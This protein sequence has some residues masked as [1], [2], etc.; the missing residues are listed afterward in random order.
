[1]FP[2]WVLLHLSE[3]PPEQPKA[4]YTAITVT[5]SMGRAAKAEELAPATTVIG[6]ES[7][8]EHPMPTI[9][10][11]LDGTPGALIQQSTSAQV[12]PFLRGLT[13]YQVL[14][15]ID[16]I[17][18]NNSTF[19][20]GPNQ[21]LAFVEPGQSQ[22]VEAV[23]GPAG[24][25]YG[26]DAMGGAIQVLTLEPRF[27]SSAKPEYGGEWM[28]FAGSADRSVGTRLRL[29]GGTSRLAWLAG[30]TVRRHN[31]IRA[32]GGADSRH[33]LR[34]FLGLDDTMIQDLTG[35]RQRNT[36]FSQSGAHAK[37]AARLTPGQVLTGWYQFSQQEGVNGYKDLWG[38]QGRLLSQFA[39]QRLHFGYARWEMLERL[40]MDR[41]S[42][43]FS[44]NDQTDGG[45]RQGLRAADT[46]TAEQSRVR[47]LGYTGQGA[48]SWG[49][50]RALVFGGEYY[51]ESVGARRTDNG[52]LVRPLYPDGSGYG[53]AGL[54]G[55][56]SDV[57]FRG[58]LAAT[59]GLR[60]TRAG[61]SS[62]SDPRYGVAGSSQSFRDLTMNASLSWRAGQGVEVFALGGRGFRAPNLND[63]G[64]IGLND[65]GYEI[66]AA[67]ARG[68][69]MGNNSS[70][71]AL[72]LGRAVETLRPE[73]LWNAEAGVRWRARRVHVEWRGFDAELA[74]P[75]ARRTL[76]F[77]LSSPPGELA[78]QPVRPNEPTAAQRAAG[79]TTVSTA[80]DP[81][82]VK[83]FV[84]DGQARYYG[85]EA[86]GRVEI[87]RGL[88]AE[89][90]YGFIAGR[91]LY[92]NRA[93]RRLPP[94]AGSAA[95]RWNP[96]R[97][98]LWIEGRLDAAGS[99]SRLSGGDL[100]DERIGASRSR[101]DIAAFFR[102]SR[103]AP[104][105]D[106]AGRFAPTGETLAQIQER[107]LPRLVAATDAL[108]V[109]LYRDTAGWWTAGIRS[110]VPVGERWTL[111][112]ALDNLADRNYRVHGSG[113][114]APGFSA[115]CGVVFQF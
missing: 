9:G 33:A 2:W 103:V 11:A 100:D 13:G 23:L 105:V 87:R 65:L 7:L 31:D 81:R 36:A 64:A 51:D 68:A 78:G 27:S 63:L 46:L 67:E 14:N 34:R 3:P 47:S 29:S 115:W 12:S 95:L 49:V 37:L 106:G 97:R 80:I 84:N 66:P 110:G 96:G 83:A 62:P 61:F 38:G 111:Q 92:P 44:L 93:I 114:D 99:Q 43:T 59:G 4:V 45:L 19:R 20:T 94:Q 48:R 30:G 50:H 90:T 113:I 28:S 79:V 56:L 52:R 16:G 57:W 35:S 75:I 74:D 25:L 39:P 69:R 76:L 58:R 24:A 53:T 88:R 1:M 5:A 32:G 112:L 55:Q 8:R 40:G 77:P 91:D 41:V 15:L 86:L 104:W 71:S 60:W 6:L 85:V 42:A 72:P 18:F 73:R 26:S 89:A 109:P 82:A 70:E 108:R 54:F 22:R 98:G 21:Y 101:N 107:V 17:R 10:H 102:G